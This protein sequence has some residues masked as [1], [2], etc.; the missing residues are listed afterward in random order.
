MQPMCG[1]LCLLPVLPSDN[2][3]PSANTFAPTAVET[4]PSIAAAADLTKPLLLWLNLFTITTPYR[5]VLTLKQPGLIVLAVAS[6]N[7][8]QSIGGRKLNVPY[9]L[10]KIGRPPAKPDAVTTRFVTSDGFLRLGRYGG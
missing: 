8:N 6:P 3:R 10:W 2:A 1:R 5:N 7:V 4:E 9:F